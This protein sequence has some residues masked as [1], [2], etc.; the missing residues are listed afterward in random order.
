VAPSALDRV[1]RYCLALPETTERLSHR[2]P[3]F[4]VSQKRSFVQYWDDHHG[5]GRV[6]LWCAAPP[7]AQEALVAADPR[8]YFRP[9]YVGGRGWVGVRVDLGPRWSEVAEIIEEAYRAV[10]PK[11]LVDRL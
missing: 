2:T 3:T 9:P 11:S 7:G 1:R 10:A 8:R 5:D 4:F 6:A